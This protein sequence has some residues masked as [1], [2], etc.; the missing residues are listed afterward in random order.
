MKVQEKRARMFT[1][2]ATVVV[3]GI[4][5]F[6]ETFAWGIRAL[7]MLMAYIGGDVPGIA[8]GR[9]IGHRRTSVRS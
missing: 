3:F 5:R 8:A 9:P 2:I 6:M 1:R 4:A 7:A